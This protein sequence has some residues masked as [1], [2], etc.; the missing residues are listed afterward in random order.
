MPILLATLALGGNI[1]VGM[2]DNVYY[3]K[4]RLAKN[5]A[6]FVHR[7]ARLVKEANRNVASLTSPGKCWG[8]EHTRLEPYHRRYW[9][10]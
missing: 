2:E 10:V 9:E 3:A 5:N 6:E 8:F 7:A 1:R 4:G